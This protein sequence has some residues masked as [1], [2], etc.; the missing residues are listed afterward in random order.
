[1]QYQGQTLVNGVWVTSAMFTELAD[2]IKWH[3]QQAGTV[4]IISPHGIIVY[5]TSGETR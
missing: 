3:S 5:G 1:M 2:A 4:R